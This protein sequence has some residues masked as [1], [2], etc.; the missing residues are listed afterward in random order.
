MFAFEFPVV[1]RPLQLSYAAVYVVLVSHAFPSIQ[2]GVINMSD[3]DF[4]GTRDDDQD[5]TKW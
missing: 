1:A 4:I 5:T 2:E 3:G